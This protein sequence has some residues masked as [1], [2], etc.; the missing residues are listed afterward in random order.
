MT[1]RWLF[2]PALL[3][4]LA[5]AATNAD[6]LPTHIFHIGIIAALP[7]SSFEHVVFEHRLRELGYVEGR[8]LTIDFAQYTDLDRLASAA[9]KFARRGVVLVTGGK[10]TPH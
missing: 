5:A 1:V 4:G 2:T 7:R 3:V 8:N 10:T 6:E 9:G